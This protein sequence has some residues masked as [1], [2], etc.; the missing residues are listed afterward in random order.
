M[1]VGPN[2]RAALNVARI[3][4]KMASSPHAHWH[5]PARRRRLGRTTAARCPALGALMRGSAYS[6]DSA[7]W[8]ASCSGLSEARTSST[9]PSPAMAVGK[10]QVVIANR[11][12]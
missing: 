3:A 1:T 8:P 5:R 7:S 10:P 4:A 9:Q 12:T 11:A 6:P 2:E